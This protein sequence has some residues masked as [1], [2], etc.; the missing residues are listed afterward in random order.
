MSDCCRVR[1][2]AGNPRSGPRI[3]EDQSAWMHARN[4]GV[5]EQ[6]T[7]L[8]GLRI[9]RVQ[10]RH[11]YGAEKTVGIDDEIDRGHAAG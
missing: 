4:T 9:D 7:A 6:P 1:D 2:A 5:L 11:V 8:A 3:A 10:T